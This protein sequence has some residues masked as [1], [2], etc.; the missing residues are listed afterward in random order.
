MPGRLSKGGAAAAAAGR[1]RGGA[2]AGGS[3]GAGDGVAVCVGA[4]WPALCAVVVWVVDV[5]W[6]EVE[7]KS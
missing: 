3:G 7:I 4:A 2:G 5:E 1:G 6:V